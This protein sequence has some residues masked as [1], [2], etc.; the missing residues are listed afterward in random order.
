MSTEQDPFD[1]I[2]DPKKCGIVYDKFEE[3]MSDNNRQFSKC[4]RELASF[5]EC[6]ERI[7]KEKEAA[8]AQS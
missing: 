1:E 7:K 3:C 2:S 4:Q 5:R 6:F 8:R